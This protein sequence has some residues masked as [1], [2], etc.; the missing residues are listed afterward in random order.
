MANAGADINNIRIKITPLLDQSI[1]TNNIFAPN[2]TLK[3]RFVM[4][5]I[6]ISYQIH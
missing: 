4:K 1:I 2:L 3:G 5:S 6:N